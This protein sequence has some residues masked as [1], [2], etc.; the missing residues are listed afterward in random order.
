MLL[1]L[2]QGPQQ[3]QTGPVPEA[4]A[5]LALARERT[6]HRASGTPPTYSE[7]S[8]HGPRRHRD[9]KILPHIPGFQSQL[10]R[11]R[12]RGYLASLP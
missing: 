12:R 4:H 5:Q 8:H 6:G 11:S 1:Q 7:L 3:L 10:R 2:P 9:R